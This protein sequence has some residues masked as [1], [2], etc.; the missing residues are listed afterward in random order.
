MPINLTEKQLEDLFISY[1][2][3]RYTQAQLANYL[4]ISQASVSKI[5]KQHGVT[6]E[7]KR[8]GQPRA[9]RRLRKG[10]GLPDRPERRK[11]PTRR[12]IVVST[13]LYALRYYPD[14]R[15]LEVDFHTNNTRY[16]FINVSKEE[17]NRISR[18]KSKGK[19]F[20]RYIRRMNK[21]IV[22]KD[23]L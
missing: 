15:V 4:G 17:F 9:G 22:Q 16:H 5:L 3:G 6:D 20:W 11:K 13:H 23:Q 8:A 7:R 2:T 18:A 21:P 10:I 14:E 12:Q 19:M 1:A